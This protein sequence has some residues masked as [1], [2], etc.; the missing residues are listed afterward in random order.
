M[1]SHY[2][3]FIVIDS[4]VHEKSLSKI[5]RYLESYLTVVPDSIDINT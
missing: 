5:I 3:K 1:K 4:G 2:P